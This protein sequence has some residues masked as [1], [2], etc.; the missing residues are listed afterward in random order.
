MAIFGGWRITRAGIVF[1]GG[2]IVLAALIWGGI[3]LVRERGEQARRDE[4][5]KVAQ[6]NLEEQSGTITETVTNDEEEQTEAST[7]TPQPSAPAA[8]LP[9]TGGSF[10][11]L[12]AITALALA[13][14][15]YA[16]SRRDLRR[17]GRIS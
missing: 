10:G 12:V 15:Y 17:A 3:W 14:A 13:G 2:I 6:E 16:S 5:V 9:A 1:I 8:E 4:A 7:Q 11:A